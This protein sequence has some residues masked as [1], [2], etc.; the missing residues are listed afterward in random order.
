MALDWYERFFARPPDVVAH[1]NEVMWHV[2]DG[3]WLYIV[4]DA[5]RA[6][7]GGV[8]MS[9]PDIEA[10]TAAL[11]E[12]GVETGRITPEGDAGLKAVAL[13]PDGNAIEILQVI[14]N[15]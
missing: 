13:D 9:V 10:V 4:R 8:A 3:A 7:N 11:K 14:G 6:G 12:R 15:G 5:D 2:T 1:D